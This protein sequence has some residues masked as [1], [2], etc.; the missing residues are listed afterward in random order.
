[1]NEEAALQVAAEVLEANL[2]EIFGPTAING[3]TARE[4]LR[5][6]RATIDAYLRAKIVA[7]SHNEE[8]GEP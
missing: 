7:N 6:V 1:M 5:L 4:R 2:R 8:D 3:L